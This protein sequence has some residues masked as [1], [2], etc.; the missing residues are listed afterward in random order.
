[1]LKKYRLDR[2]IRILYHR[3]KNC[4][5]SESYSR[6]I[7]QTNHCSSQHF[8]H[9]TLTNRTNDNDNLSIHLASLYNI[10]CLK[11]TLLKSY[12][13]YKHI[14]YETSSSNIFVEVPSS[15]S[16]QY[17]VCDWI[18]IIYLFFQN[19]TYNFLRF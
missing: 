13:S 19:S 6:V 15:C 3:Q 17:F 7:Q 1:M 12:G 9:L 5:I 8:C 11:K 10:T 2:R 14:N 4:G 16:F 18:E